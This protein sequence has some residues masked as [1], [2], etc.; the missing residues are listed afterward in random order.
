ML[1]KRSFGKH[2]KLARKHQ[3]LTVEQLAEK[4]DISSKSI[5]QIESGKCATTISGLVNLCN[6]LKV[7]PEY[8]LSGD[9]NDDFIKMKSEYEI[10]YKQIL[11]LTPTELKLIKD[12][13]NLLITN[14]SE[15]RG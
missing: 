8:L 4:L 10:L 15:Y 5:W 13:S 9:L 7:S 12:I 2:I 1:D 11:N 14:R 3:N 6:I